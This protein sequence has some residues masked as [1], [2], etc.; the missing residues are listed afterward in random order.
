M[1]SSAK[2]YKEQSKDIE[3]QFFDFDEEN[4]IVCLSRYFESPDEI[5]DLNAHT[6]VPVMRSDFIKWLTELFDYVPKKYKLDIEI[7]LRDLGGFSEQELTEICRK[8][9]ILERKVQTRK[10][11]KQNILAL[12]LC[13]TGLSL[14]LLYIWLDSV[15]I[16]GGT[17]KTVIMFILEILA[18]VPFWGAIDIFLVSNGEQRTIVQLAKKSFHGITIK[19]AAVQTLRL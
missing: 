13:T 16:S 14:A 10:E 11:N 6:K 15:W 18:T 17:L 3:K 19:K 7:T 2:Q 9:M 4:R 12:F 5:L 8:N 1:K